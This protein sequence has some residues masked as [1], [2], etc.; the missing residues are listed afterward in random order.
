MLFYCFDAHSRRFGLEGEYASVRGA[1][2]F[3]CLHIGRIIA[4]WQI[5][6]K[7][8]AVAP[9]YI[10]GYLYIEYSAFFLKALAEY[11]GAAV[12]IAGGKEEA[13]LILKR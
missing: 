3:L 11:S 13:R 5:D 7:F 1:H 6:I 8:I 2:F 4:V 10:R 9:A 12:Y